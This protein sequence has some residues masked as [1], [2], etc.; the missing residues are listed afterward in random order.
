MLNFVFE[1]INN[2]RNLYNEEEK[3]TSGFSRVVMSPYVNRLNQLR[4]YYSKLRDGEEGIIEY[5]GNEYSINIYDSD[6]VINEKYIIPI[7]VIQS[8]EHWIGGR[9]SK[10]EIERNL[11]DLFSKL[12]EKYLNDLQNKK[13]FLLFDSSQE[14]YFDYFIFDYFHSKCLEYNISPTQI[15]Y[16]SGNS[17]IEDRLV[18]WS[19]KTSTKDLIQVIPYSHFEFDVS[20]V[21]RNRIDLNLKKIPN[22]QDQFDY[23]V[24]NFNNI[25]IFNFLNKKS[26]NHRIWFYYM[27]KKFN[28]LKHGLVSMNSFDNNSCI[29]IDSSILNELEIEYTLKDLPT[30]AY[31]VSNEVE[32]FRFY[33]DN[34]NEQA[35]LDSWLTIVSEAQ[36]EDSQETVF[37]SEKVF[38]PIACQHPFVIL[39][40]KGS[41]K[42]LKK[43]GYK[44]FHDLIDESYDNMNS[45]DRFHA[46]KD[47]INTLKSNR[48][49]LEW[50]GWLRPTLEHNSKVLLFNS[51]FKPPIGFH[52]LMELLK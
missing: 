27:L 16:V 49:K 18:D 9:Y 41:L 28:L 52:K 25:K 36:Y 24:K 46:I 3:L 34:L 42:E 47:I 45:N 4:V 29:K 2:L 23:K 51:I 10:S 22:F 12:S 26:R 11:P 40:N 39:G 1:D 37:L 5:L 17:V 35:T 14:G 19:K 21:V 33:M 43:L 38:K 20:E 15:I 50:F 31:G 44:T 48:D 32:P 30:Y 8:P 7:G 13:A 6:K